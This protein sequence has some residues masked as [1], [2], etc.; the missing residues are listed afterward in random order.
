M[1]KLD[2]ITSSTRPASP[3]AGKAYFETDT[4]KIIVWDGSAWTEL[5][6]DNAVS[7]FTNDYSVSFPGTNEYMSIPDTD[8]WSLGDGAGTDNPISF[9]LWFNSAS[10]STTYLITK[11]V[12]TS[13]NDREWVFRTISGKLYFFARGTGGGIIG[14]YYNT[15]LNSSQW[16]HT[17]VTYDGS[18]A[19]SGLKIYL[20]GSRVDDTDYSFAGYS[21]ARNGNAEVR[22]ASYELTG[23]VSNCLIDEVALFNTELSASD[24]ASLRD[25]SGSNPAPADI[26][27]LSPVGWWRMGDNDNGA[28][29][30]ITDQGSG[31][32]NGALQNSPAFSSNV[33]S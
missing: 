30:T 6:S 22:V 25:T 1:A 32:N 29:N 15:A 16:Y 9:S 21:S 3:A 27:S 23:A 7:S 4:N 24:V 28:G 11:E 20:D 14:R 31:S 2:L 5:V 19:S 17:V 18:K 8:V 12:N 13:S 10:I 26:S 33:P